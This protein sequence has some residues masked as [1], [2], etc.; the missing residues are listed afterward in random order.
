MELILHPDATAVIKRVQRPGFYVVSGESGIGKKTA[1]LQSLPSAAVNVVVAEKAT[2]TLEQMRESTKHFH[3]RSGSSQEYLVI[4]D[5]HLLSTAAQNSLLK[6]LEE[7]PSHVTVIM[8]T[9]QP[10]LLL[11]TIQSRAFR[12]DIPTPRTEQIHQWI[13]QSGLAAEQQSVL[14]EMAGKRPAALSEYLQDEALR[15][16][17][18]ERHGIFERLCTGSLNER[19]LAA[20]QLQPHMPDV[21]EHIVQFCR[22]RLRREGG[23]WTNIVRAAEHAQR[24]SAANCNKKFV[25]DAIAIRSIA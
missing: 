21:L 11:S 16:T 4:D 3:L 22:V 10:H 8:I 25:L 6:T 1:I 24:L 5:A 20:Y 13:E 18:H 19:L 2:I 9:H 15:Q 17:W 7:L 12:L 23:E 14:F